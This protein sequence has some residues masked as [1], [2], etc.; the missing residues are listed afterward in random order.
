MITL[1]PTISLT[2]SVVR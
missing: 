2:M 1:Q